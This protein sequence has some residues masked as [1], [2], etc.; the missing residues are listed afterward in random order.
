M[1]EHL[2]VSPMRRL[3]WLGLSAFVAT[4]ALAQSTQHNESDLDF[5]DRLSSRTGYLT[6][7]LDNLFAATGHQRSGRSATN[8]GGTG[9]GIDRSTDTYG[10]AATTG[11]SDAFVTESEL[12]RVNRK[13]VSISRKLEKER[14]SLESGE[15]L[16]D[17]QLAKRD[18][19]LQQIN[20]DLEGLERDI[21]I[22][23]KQLR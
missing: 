17:R 19:K 1:N 6:S 15:K 13:L 7:R 18:K 5:V 11:R 8:S 9:F 3:L 12:N 20:R 16:S 14:K 2:R 22:M 23:E 21:N 10:S 4:T